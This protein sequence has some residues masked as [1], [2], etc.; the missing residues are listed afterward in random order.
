MAG[1]KI[2]WGQTSL[3]QEMQILKFTRNFWNILKKTVE[4]FKTFSNI[5]ETSVT[6]YKRLAYSRKMLGAYAYLH[7]HHQ[8]HVNPPFMP[9]AHNCHNT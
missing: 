8:C 9:N 2:Q 4:L 1:D 7:P 3:A 5:W 6:F